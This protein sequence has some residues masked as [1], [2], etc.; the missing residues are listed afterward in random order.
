MRIRKGLFKQIPALEVKLN[1]TCGIG[2]VRNYTSVIT[3]L[4]DAQITK[5]WWSCYH[6]IAGK[7]NSLTFPCPDNT[8]VCSCAHEPGH[9]DPRYGWEAF[10]PGGINT[11]Y[12]E[13]SIGRNASTNARLSG[14]PFCP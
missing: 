3:N 7:P 1:T 9:Y 6:T 10:Y 11:F 13:D 8:L 4:L 14:I 2:T 5:T 12:I